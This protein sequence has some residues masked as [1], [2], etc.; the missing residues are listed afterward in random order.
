MKPRFAFDQRVGVGKSVKSA[1]R[2][3]IAIG[4]QIDVAE[5]S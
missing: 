2:Y 4:I 1:N 5:T 3:V